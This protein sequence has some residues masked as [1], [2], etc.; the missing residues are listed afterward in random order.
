MSKGQ[1]DS[2]RYVGQELHQALR[3]LFTERQCPNITIYHNDDE[4][5]GESRLS[6]SI[7]GLEVHM[8]V[9]KTGD[10]YHFQASVG[11]KDSG[12]LETRADKD[13]KLRRSR[14]GRLPNKCMDEL[15]LESLKYLKDF[16]RQ[17]Q[18]KQ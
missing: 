5:R 17:R 9:S 3:R 1:Y 11:V 12:Y 10:C 14:D 8:L 6:Y 15:A 13:L 18:A 7:S 16:N 2:I 4:G